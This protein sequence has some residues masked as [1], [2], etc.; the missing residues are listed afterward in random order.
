MIDYISVRD[1]VELKWLSCR[2]LLSTA[3]TC[4]Y[5]S[6]VLLFNYMTVRDCANFTWLSCKHVL[7]TADTCAPVFFEL[8]T[9]QHVT[10]SS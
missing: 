8:I 10:V 3:D 7:S 4:T 6:S 1:C 9:F 5:C 2:A